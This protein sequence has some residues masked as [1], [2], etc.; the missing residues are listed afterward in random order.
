MTLSQMAP[1][2]LTSVLLKIFLHLVLQTPYIDS[3]SPT[4]G[5]E[6]GGT[7]IVIRGGLLSG[8]FAQSPLSVMLESLEIPPNFEE[9]NITFE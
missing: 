4:Y 9:C 3:V 7:S 5:P 8:N 2:S 6:I 1:A